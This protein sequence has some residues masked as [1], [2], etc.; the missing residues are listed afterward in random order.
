MHNKV[1]SAFNLVVLVAAFCTSAKAAAAK[2]ANGGTAQVQSREPALEDHIETAHAG[3]PDYIEHSAAV[4]TPPGPPRH[5]S[6][7]AQQV[8]SA[9]PA[10]S[11]QDVEPSNSH[12]KRRLVVTW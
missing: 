2:P 8:S 5:A 10:T 3:A 4:S 11:P 6:L 9:V 1:A 12:L 7:T